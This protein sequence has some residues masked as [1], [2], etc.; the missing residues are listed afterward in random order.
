MAS[1]TERMCCQGD[2]LAIFCWFVIRD[3]EV[4]LMGKGKFEGIVSAGGA[5][6]KLGWEPRRWLVHGG[7]ET[8]DTCV[9]MGRK[10]KLHG[11]QPG[12]CWQ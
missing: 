8:G 9:D 11:K 4:L 1:R 7:G 3:I 12:R 5:R 6:E 2:L 10:K